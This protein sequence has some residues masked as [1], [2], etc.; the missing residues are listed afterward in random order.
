MDGGGRVS[1]AAAPGLAQVACKGTDLPNSP[2]I[3]SGKE[4][5]ADTL[6]FAVS[7]VWSGECGEGRLTF[8]VLA[9]KGQG[10]PDG[11]SCNGREGGSG[12]FGLTRYRVCNSRECE[13]F[14]D[15]ANHESGAWE[16]G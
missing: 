4:F 11:R 2:N 7:P 8:A 14:L 6:S 5:F 13:G 10:I 1:D 12:G 16:P 15:A 3:S 9:E